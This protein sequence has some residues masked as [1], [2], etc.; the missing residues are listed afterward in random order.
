[1]RLEPRSRS[2]ATGD[3]TGSLCPETHPPLP[4]TGSSDLQGARMIQIK[5][6][7]LYLAYFSNESRTPN[8]Y[9]QI[10]CP[11][12]IKTAKKDRTGREKNNFVSVPNKPDEVKTEAV[13]K[14]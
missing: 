2:R 1:M 10:I 4:S 11:E 7:M 5:V 13:W 8:F 6:R 14:I 9:S 3:G 12:H